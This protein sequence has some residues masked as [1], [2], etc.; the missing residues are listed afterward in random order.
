MPLAKL[1][2]SDEFFL[3]LL[4]SFHSFCVRIIEAI[5]PS[6]LMSQWIIFLRAHL[7]Y[8][9]I[10]TFFLFYFFPFEIFTMIVI[11]SGFKVCQIRYEWDFYNR[12]RYFSARNKQY[13]KIV[14]KM[15]EVWCWQTNFSLHSW[16]FPSL[17][18]IKITACLH[19]VSVWDILI[20]S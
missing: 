7:Q 13:Y 5:S 8:S 15:V 1:L 4:Y 12:I 18:G 16:L 11:L 17:I 6:P 2:L 3:L 14:A 9:N 19:W 20:K 10:V